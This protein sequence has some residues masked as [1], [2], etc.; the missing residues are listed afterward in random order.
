MVEF[1]KKIPKLS[2]IWAKQYLKNGDRNIHCGLDIY[3]EQNTNLKAPISGIV[4][5]GYNKIEDMNYLFISDQ[6]KEIEVIV[7]NILYETSILNKYV[8]SGDY[9]GKVKSPSFKSQINYSLLFNNMA[10]IHFEV[11]CKHLN[12]CSEFFIYNN[13]IYYNGLYLAKLNILK[14]PI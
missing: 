2:R 5:E 12:I 8:S 14:F 7:G 4:S 3:V 1:A 11:F 6:E 10:H 13:N 9:I